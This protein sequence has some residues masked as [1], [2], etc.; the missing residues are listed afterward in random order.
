MRLFILASTIT[1]LAGGPVAAQEPEYSSR[2]DDET[3][4]APLAVTLLEGTG[5]LTRAAERLPL[6]G[7]QPLLEGD[8]LRTDSGRLEVRWPEGHVLLLDAR[9]TLDVVT[10]AS[11]RL[12][13]G[14]LRLRVV[15]PGLRDGLIIDTPSGTARFSHPG[16]FRLRAG[17]VQGREAVELLTIRGLAELTTDRERVR[18]SGG[19]LVTARPFGQPYVRP[20]VPADAPF[21]GWVDARL[22]ELDRAEHAAYLPDPL[23]HYAPVLDRHGY[24]GHEPSYGYVWY[25]T[26]AVAWRP[27]SYGSWGHVGR[28]GWTWIGLDPWAWP[29]HHYGRWGFSPHGRWFWIPGH[30]WGPAWVSWVVGPGHIGWSPLGFNNRPV[31]SF[32]AGKVFVGRAGRFHDQWASWTVLPRHH[33]RPRVPVWRHAIDGRGLPAHDLSAFVRQRVPPVRAGVN[34]TSPSGGRHAVP[35][36][37]GQPDHGTPARMAVPRAGSRIDAASAPATGMGAPAASQ[38]ADNPYERARRVQ[39]RPGARQAVPHHP[40]QVVVPRTGAVPRADAVAGPPGEP[41]AA[42]GGR[43]SPDVTSPSGGRVRAPAYAVP[44]GAPAGEPPATTPAP[45]YVPRHRDAPAAAPPASPPRQR[46]GSEGGEP[47]SRGGSRAAPRGEAAPAAAAPPPA[48]RAAPAAGQAGGGQSDSGARR[49]VPRRGS[50]D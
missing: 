11:L 12:T 30:R 43:R 26:V 28:F 5:S 1:M 50:N 32:V 47:P 17:Q 31:F 4:P 6:E 25:P 39:D 49:A 44:R 19:E 9:S 41:A 23:Q 48:P 37:G 38:P 3:A 15:D 40:A 18:V 20:G 42:A 16:D 46:G 7:T 45:V 22:A 2:F 34:V 8:R 27:Y 33:F 13:E 36:D 24:W 21:D 10:D 14:L 35:R 29:T